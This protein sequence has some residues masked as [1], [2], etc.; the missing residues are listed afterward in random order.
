MELKFLGTGSAYNPMLKNT[1]A[2]LPIGRTM[3]LFDCGETAFE[4]LFAK[5]NLHDFDTFFIAIT[6]FHSDH[7]GSLGSFTSYCHCRLHKKVY[8]CYPKRDICVFLD[9]TGVSPEMYTYVARPTEDMG[10]L[11]ELTAMEVQHDP[12]IDCYGYLVRLPGFR[13]FYGGDSVAV[14]R[15]AL[16]LLKSGELDRIYQDVTYEANH[17][18]DCH[19]TLERICAQI[20]ASLRSR[21]TCMHFDHDF[22]DKIE[23]CGFCAARV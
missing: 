23:A 22:T 18:S 9:K 2:Y 12:M 11:F 17:E 7:I 13:F 15:Q 20:P 1:N 14:P 21:V 8:I 5:E 19:G 16:D 4:T 10:S 3:L 6:H